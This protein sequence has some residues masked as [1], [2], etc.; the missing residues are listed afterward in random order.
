M[1]SNADGPEC[2][3]KKRE[4]TKR[5]QSRNSGSGSACDR[6]K[7]RRDCAP[8]KWLLCSAAARRCF[9]LPKPTFPGR[10][11]GHWSMD[12]PRLAARLL[13]RLPCFF[14]CVLWRPCV[15][16]LRFRRGGSV[17]SD[18][19]RLDNAG[20]AGR[21]LVFLSGDAM[22]PLVTTGGL[23]GKRPQIGPGRFSCV[24]DTGP[25]RITTL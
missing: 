16:G 17:H 25:Y 19:G 14:S 8:F 23:P 24:G 2:D 21:V 13:R 1:D 6:E 5:R 10:A 12:Y 11:P 3:K 4:K 9:F 7:P 15:C 18:G 20:G 22:L